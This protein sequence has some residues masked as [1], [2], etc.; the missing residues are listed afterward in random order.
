MIHREGDPLQKLQLND[1]DVVGGGANAM[2]GGGNNGD[3]VRG[4][5][6]TMMSYSA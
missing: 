5:K 3:V 6:N 1:G 4:G 2:A